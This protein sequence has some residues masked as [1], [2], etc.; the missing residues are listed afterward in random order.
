MV[1]NSVSYTTPQFDFYKRT[2]SLS[3]E[4]VP[5]PAEDVSTHEGFTESEAEDPQTA[6]RAVH[7]GKHITSIE[8]Y[9]QVNTSPL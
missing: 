3:T 5:A 6:P 7:P 9:I 2:L 8:Q 1:I 4:H